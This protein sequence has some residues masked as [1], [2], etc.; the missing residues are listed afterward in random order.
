MRNGQ[1]DGGNICAAFPDRRYQWPPQVCHHCPQ[2]HQGS[3]FI[4]GT[5]KNW[6]NTEPGSWRIP[7]SV[8]KEG[9]REGDGNKCKL[10]VGDEVPHLPIFSSQGAS[11]PEEVPQEADVQTLRNQ[12]PRFH[13]SHQQDGWVPWEVTSLR[14]GKMYTRRRHP[15]VG[16]FLTPEG[17]VKITHHPGVWICNPRPHGDRWVLWAPRNYWGNI[18]GA[19]WRKSPKQKNQA[20]WWTPPIH[21]V[22]SEKRVKPGY[23]PL[24]RGLKKKKSKK[25]ITCVPS[26]WPWSR[27]EIVQGHTGTRQSHDVDLVNHS[28]QRR[29]P[30]KVP[31]L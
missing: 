2:D 6:D 15:R 7:A 3:G 5:P 4:H 28:R 30:R 13:L 25:K 17:V 22:G 20:V 24:V 18:P 31:G 16:R 8:R 9:S 26:A 29:R 21:Q 27:H 11:E 10:W 23:E 12:Y 14:G 1:R 19:R